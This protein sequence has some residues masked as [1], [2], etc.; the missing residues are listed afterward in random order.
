MSEASSFWADSWCVRVLDYTMY[1]GMA[2]IPMAN[3]AYLSCSLPAQ[4]EW[5]CNYFS[6][7]LITEKNMRSKFFRF[8][9]V[10]VPM[11]VVLSFSYCDSQT[12][13]RQFWSVGRV[14]FM[15]VCSKKI[16]VCHGS[17]TYVNFST[18]ITSWIPLD[19]RG[20]YLYSLFHFSPVLL[21]L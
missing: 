12:T 14:L 9:A 18:M 20:I 17:Y 13:S 10:R 3:L 16:V 4:T 5:S 6:W 2:I 19:G 11:V 15:P 7:V 21:V 8:F 1:M